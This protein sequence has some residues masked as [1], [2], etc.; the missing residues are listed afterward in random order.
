MERLTYE[1]IGACYEVRKELG[2]FLYENT[3]ELALMHELQLRNIDCRNQ[4]DIPINYK[5]MVIGNACRADIVVENKIVLEL[6]ALDYMG[7][8]EISQLMSYM[9]FGNFPLG[10]L[11]NFGAFDFTTER[12]NLEDYLYKGI[13]RFI[14]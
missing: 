5:G 8:N 2:R 7:K 4:V 11:I 13:Y 12:P 6:K 9:T 10:F 3:Y 1:I 14:K